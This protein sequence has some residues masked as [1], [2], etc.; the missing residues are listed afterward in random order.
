MSILVIGKES[1]G[2]SQLIAALTGQ[3]PYSA[4][5]RGSTVAV[6]GYRG[7]GHEFV[8]TPGLVQHSD[9]DTT[10]RALA[11]LTSA[12][13]V[14]VVAK[15]THLDDD[16]RDLWPLLHHKQ[17]AVA[18]TFWDKVGIQP[19][20]RQALAALSAA[21]GVPMIPVDARNLTETDRQAM[22]AAVAAPHPFPEQ[23]RGRVG[24][25]IEPRPTVLEH[26]HV[27]PW[28][29]LALLLAPAVLA[30]WA[31]NTVAGLVE[32]LVKA[33]L[34]PVWA[35]L[36]AL[37]GVL[38]AVLVG[39]YGFLTMFP[40][41]FVWAMPTVLV[42]A[43]MLGAYKASGLL[44]R[45]TVALH[46]WMRPLGVS[47]RDVVRV[48]MGFGCNV[49]AII[50]TRACSSCTR[51]T[52]MSAIAFGSACSYQLGAT[53]GVF[54]AAQWPQLVVPYLGYLV[55]TTLLFTRWVSQPEARAAHNTLLITGRT[56]LEWPRPS[57]VWREA[58]SE[59]GEFLG[60]AMPIFLGI[61]VVA[62]VLNELGVLTALAGGLAPLMALF[63]LPASA[64]L[65]VLLASI[66]K[67]GL[68][69]FAEPGTL[70][71]LTGW[72]LL[73]GVYLAGVLL[74]CLVTAYTVAR[75]QSWRYAAGLMARQALAAL[76][77][78]ALLAW[79]G[80]ALGW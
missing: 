31:A 33:G 46:P 63:N 24:W 26:R 23:V 34:E 2:K 77:F 53:L 25:R 79:G 7:A 5:F 69:L 6:H 21:T 8:D 72:Q 12:E 80:F 51:R 16:L 59:I 70:A 20:N 30:V 9:T 28:L 49:P 56:F 13:Q 27:G 3:A 74:P 43:L 47:G 76:F 37:P 52:T 1:T 65:P 17:G 38:G 45:M 62:A 57:A 60:K 19:S 71:G 15:A 66:R 32:P 54:A 64:A 48:V 35:A 18:V 4:N 29:A 11:A 22:L 58:R 14:L 36:A 39:P 40:L 10:R 41:L 68:L 73:T 44:E 75:E 42:Y 78:S 50:S 61:T 55:L 67:D